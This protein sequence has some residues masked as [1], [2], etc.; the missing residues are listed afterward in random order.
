MEERDVGV[1]ELV[2]LAGLHP[3]HFRALLLRAP[4]GND[5]VPGS[6]FT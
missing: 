5:L 4:D 6:R 2:A 1:V 3:L